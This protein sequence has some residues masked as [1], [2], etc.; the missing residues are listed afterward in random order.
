[1]GALKVRLLGKFALSYGGTP[2]TAVLPQRCQCLLASL[3]LHRDA[4][5]SRQHLAFLLF[6][7]STESQAHTNLRH[8]IHAL[9]EA[10]PL[11]VATCR[12]LIRIHNRR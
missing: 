1:M 5:Q 11:C 8:I 12:R 3:L 4:P 9:K 6:P 10:L 2:L 7:D